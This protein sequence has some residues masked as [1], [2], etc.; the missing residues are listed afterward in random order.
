[1]ENASKALYMAAEVLLGILLLTLMV[2]LMTAV[3]NFSNQI[4]SNISTKL[5][6]EFNAKFEDYNNR[7][8]LT[9]Q[10]V[11]TLSNLVKDYNSNEDE[12]YKKIEIEI[13]NVSGRYKNAIRDNTLTTNQA[14]DFMN[15]YAPEI[16]GDNTIKKTVFQ[17]SMKYDDNT[18][19]IEKIEL[20][21]MSVTE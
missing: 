14:I 5:I 2:A 9:P 13:S 21:A 4:D 19:T 18:G 3:Q 6:A 1:M 12:I 11:V 20:K 17:C 15:D 7:T 8:N 16:N 10:D